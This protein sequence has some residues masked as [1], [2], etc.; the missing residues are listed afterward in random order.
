MDL[1]DDPY[2]KKEIKFHDVYSPAELLVLDHLADEERNTPVVAKKKGAKDDPWVK[3]FR[4]KDT[5]SKGMIHNFFFFE[6]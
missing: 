4:W 5:D 2:S 6:I 1:I 3:A